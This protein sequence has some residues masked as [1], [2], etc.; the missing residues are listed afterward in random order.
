METKP[1]SVENVAKQILSIVPENESQIRNM[2][3]NFID[4]LWNQAPET[5]YGSYNWTKFI[6]LLNSIQW[7]EKAE[8]KKQIQPILNGQS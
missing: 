4:G 7:P 5:L 2:L 1:R 8:W 3:T 6:G